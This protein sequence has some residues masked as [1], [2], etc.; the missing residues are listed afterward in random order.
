MRRR[1]SQSNLLLGLVGFAIILVM[2]VILV[3]SDVGVVVAVILAIAALWY[4]RI[5][6]NRQIAVDRT[7]HALDQL[8]SLSG[9]EFEH[10]VAELYRRL[11]YDVKITRGSGDQGVDVIAQSSSQKLGIQCKQWSGTVGNDA[12]QQALSGRVFYNCSNAA[13]VC[14]STFTRSARELAERANVQLIDGLAYTAMVSKSFAS[15]WFHELDL[16]H[17]CRADGLA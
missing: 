6:V 16:A 2:G 14:T 10:H 4:G 9:I 11:G 7:W 13:V 12:V 17:G 3:R 8:R 15:H 5:A 1:A